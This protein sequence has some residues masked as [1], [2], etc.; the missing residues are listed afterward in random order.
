MSRNNEQE[1]T[2]KENLVTRYKLEFAVR[3]ER[4]DVTS[5]MQEVV[6]LENNSKQNWI[7]SAVLKFCLS[8]EVASLPWFPL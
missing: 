5:L 1:T 2:S 4:D 8:G 7:G 6:R 3:R